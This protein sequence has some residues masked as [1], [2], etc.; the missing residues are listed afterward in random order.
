M[1]N[2]LESAGAT[3]DGGRYFAAPVR[4]GVP[5]LGLALTFQSRP[6]LGESFA[7]AYGESLELAAEADRLGVDDIWVSEHHGEADGYCPSPVVAAAAI[8]GVTRRVQICLGIALA[9]LYGH[10]LRLAEDL[11]VVDNLSGG[12]LEAGFGQGY[13][14]LE[15]EAL[16]ADFGRRTR[17]FS[18]ALD[19][20]DLAWPGEP[21]DYDGAVYR[22]HGGLLRPAPVRPGLPSVWLGAAT[23]R[24][25]SRAVRRRTGLMIA[26]LTTA[27]QT[28]RQ[29][30][31][32]DAESTRV[33][34]GSLPHTLAREIEVG[35][36]DDDARAQVAPFLDYTYRV[37][38]SPERTGMT[39]NDP[40]TGERRPLVS[41][42]PYYLSP[43]FLD[44]RWA[45][46]SPESVAERITAWQGLMRLDRLL[47]GKLPG[48]PLAD[49]VRAVERVVKEVWPVL[50]AQNHEP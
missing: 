31:S 26:P 11:S 22:V 17:S 5:R 47:L 15:F 14:P 45:I 28:A 20:F 33:G 48:R 4:P 12:R 43:A 21:F 37:Q 42:D 6:D 1:A 50:Q 10:P 19:V 44:E 3:A 27:E 40:A 24:S 30:A 46:G 2:T 25:R 7:T 36:S 32:F 8:A 49:S 9:P 16:G 39:R 13:R 18:E 23:S 35:D 29:F 41:S 34:A 38:Y